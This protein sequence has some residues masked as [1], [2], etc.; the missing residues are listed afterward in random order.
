MTKTK[1]ILSLILNLV[2]ALVTTG[3]VI[4][5]FCGNTG[6]LI[7]YGYESFK[8][9]T[10]D[11][12]VL[13]AIAAV[14]VAAW[15]IRLL[16]QPDAVLPAWVIALKYVGTVAVMLTFCTVIF[17]LAPLYGPAAVLSNTSF[18]M[19]AA[20]PLFSLFSF[21]FLETDGRLRFY[22]TA[23]SIIPTLLYAIVYTINVVFIGTWNDFYSFNAGGFWYITAPIMIAASYLISVF[24]F[25]LHNRMVRLSVRQIAKEDK[26]S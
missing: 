26:T 22:L 8:F 10:T 7:Q 1:T 18:H 2:I 21:C 16:K 13:A 9:F 24:T 14:C 25:A 12:N 3:I 15:D 11:S 20:A 19:H 6:V 4:S 5:Y 23:V 17:F